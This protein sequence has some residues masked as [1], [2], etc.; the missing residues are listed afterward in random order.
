MGRSHGGEKA[1]AVNTQWE[2]AGPLPALPQRQSPPSLYTA[3]EARVAT[4]EGILGPARP[5]KD[6]PKYLV[7]AEGN[8]ARILAQRPFLRPQARNHVTQGHEPPLPTMS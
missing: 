1:R 5:R 4:P 8:R 2:L 6:K 7:S 3:P